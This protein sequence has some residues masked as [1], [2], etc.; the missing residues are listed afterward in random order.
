[1]IRFKR[2]THGIV[3]RIDDLIVQVENHDAAVASALREFEQGVARSRVRLGRVKRD[4]EALRR[5][6]AEEREA[7]SRW[8]ERARREAD[9]ARALE[10]LRRCKRAESRAAEL[11]RRAKEHDEVAAALDRDVRKL[12]E[13]MVELREQRNTLLTRESRASAY[14]A[15]RDGVDPRGDI[16]QALERWEAQIA[17]AEI[18]TGCALLE[19]DD[20]DDRYATEEEQVGLELELRALRE[21]AR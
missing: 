6:L 3:A 9:G 12:E 15:I 7:A 18:A 4:G 13:R 2:W 1:M 20:L 5:A 8:R 10:C 14:G 21:E 17:E 19:R 16:G 11:E